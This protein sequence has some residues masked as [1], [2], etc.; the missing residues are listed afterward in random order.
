MSFATRSPKSDLLSLLL[1]EK[2]NSSGLVRPDLLTL[3]QG[4]YLLLIIIITLIVLK[5]YYKAPTWSSAICVSGVQLGR[6]VITTCQPGA[7]QTTK[8]WSFLDVAFS[9]NNLVFKITNT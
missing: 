7:R 6:L 3:V 8:A 5:N 9:D 1:C 4:R 2:D